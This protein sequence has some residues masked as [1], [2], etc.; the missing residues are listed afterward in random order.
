LDNSKF[1]YNFNSGAMVAAFAALVCMCLFAPFYLSKEKRNQES[2]TVVEIP[3]SVAF[4]DNELDLATQIDQFVQSQ[5]NQIKSHSTGRSEAPFWI[6]TEVSSGLAF[7]HS[8]SVPSRHVSDL[9]CWQYSAGTKTLRTLVVEKFNSG[10]LVRLETIG[11]PALTVVLACRVKAIGPA[12]IKLFVNKNSYEAEAIKSYEREA[13]GVQGALIALAVFCMVIACVSREY[14]YL[15]FSLWLIFSE[16]LASLSIGS[17]T[18]FLWLEIPKDSLSFSRKVSMAGYFLSSVALFCALVLPQ[19]KSQFR[20]AVKLGLLFCVGGFILWL[21]FDYGKSLPFMWGLSAIGICFAAT[22]LALAWINQRSRGI[23]WYAMSWSTLFAGVVWEIVSAITGISISAFPIDSVAGTLG[24]ALFCSMCL[25]EKLNTERAA[26]QLAKSQAIDALQKFEH[27]YQQVPVALASFG[28]NGELNKC[29]RAFEDSFLNGG[30]GVSKAV[31]SKFD[32]KSFGELFNKTVS[33]RHEAYGDRHYCFSSIVGNSIV[34]IIAT[35]ITAQKIAE[36]KLQEAANRDPL[37]NLYNRF[38]M[39]DLLEQR[40]AA[41]LN[42][43][44]LTD[45]IALFDIDAFDRV[46]TNFGHGVGDDVLLAY[47]DRVQELLPRTATLGRL[48][49]DTLIVLMPSTALSEAR[50]VAQAI[51]NSIHKS[52]FET[53]VLTVS[54][55]AS[56]GVSVVES[57][58]SKEVLAAC[59]SALQDAKDKG[60]G[61]L[62]AYGERDKAWLAHKAEQELMAEFSQAIPF[63]RFEIVLQ[64]IVS[65]LNAKEDIR[66]E[67]LIR[68]KDVDGKLLTPDT[69][70]PALEKIGLMSQLD[71]WVVRQVLEFLERESDHFAKLTY[72]SLN[73]SGASINDE[74]FTD[75]L[76]RLA[77]KH[78]H[79]VRKM[80]FEIT[81]N[82]ALADMEAT[83]RFIHRLRIIGARI[84]LDDFG[85][86]YSSF[87]YL[88]QLKVD[89]IKIDG[90]LIKGVDDDP[91][92]QAI[93]KTIVDLGKALGSEVVAEWVETPKI[94]STLGRL[95]VDAGQGWA[96]GRPVS[97]SSIAAAEHGATFITD[98]N[99]TAILGISLSELAN[100]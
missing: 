55:K 10:S 39:I 74:R 50:Y 43:N 97:M 36:E 73:L 16:R 98:K 4:G 80:C 89:S 64:P 26:K 35:D 24:S 75:E 12:T 82:I 87:N 14:L 6:S 8:I 59:D 21:P 33:N 78:P 70:L 69:F 79:L 84:A 94:L 88:A 22:G 54:I 3:F 86:G 46:I 63:E 66:Y 68:M 30:H 17:D 71:R 38:K 83:K 15:T 34:E 29:N 44:T 96:L 45:C 60:G 13:I 67:A 32:G 25:A 58:T 76:L 57:K 40:L 7:G 85:A 51:L 90:S 18:S 61:Q 2:K 5:K 56:V 91:A 42:S 19:I 100:A 47:R 52:P 53:R 62:V 92:K 27:T 49:A 28:L 99:I 41:D 72:A 65:L 81:E 20:K 48:S 77:A 37:T 93:V 95:G 1:Q 11:I 23:F 9:Q 31:S